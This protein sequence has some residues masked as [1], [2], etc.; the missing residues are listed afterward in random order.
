MGYEVGSCPWEQGEDV[1]CAQVGVLGETREHK[2][3]SPPWGRGCPPCLA[4]LPEV[5]G[6]AGRDSLSPGQDQPCN[7]RPWPC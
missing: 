3:G 7:L 1:P 5:G 6:N 4:Q 2:A